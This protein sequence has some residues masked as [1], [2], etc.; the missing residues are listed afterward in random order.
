ML[1]RAARR[2]LLRLLCGVLEMSALDACP[3]SA[4]LPRF[5][6]ALP[7]AS[8]LPATASPLQLMLVSAPF[9]LAAFLSTPLALALSCSRAVAALCA[10]ATHTS[11]AA[12]PVAAATTKLLVCTEKCLRRTTLCAEPGPLQAEVALSHITFARIEDCISTPFF[13][14][15]GKKRK[16]ERDLLYLLESMQL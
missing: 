8:R 3:R 14:T 15:K 10:A 6:L 5:P 7:S 9:T 16:A 12:P 1:P 11:P 13:L 4:S 2:P